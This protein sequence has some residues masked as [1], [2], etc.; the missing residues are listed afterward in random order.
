MQPVTKQAASADFPQE[1]LSALQN[2]RSALG[3]LLAD[4]PG[5]AATPTD[6]QRGL[7]IDMTLS[8]KIHKVLRASTPVAAGPHVPGMPSMRALLKAAGRQGVS[9]ELI[10]ATEGAAREFDR[11][12]SIHAGDRSTFESMVC[13][14][15]T[16]EEAE[17]VDLNYR[18]SAYRSARHIWG[19]SAKTRL[20]CRVIRP[21]ADP[22]LVDI[23]GVQGYLSLRKL[24]S[25]ARLVISHARLTYDNGSKL[26]QKAEPL[27][28][29]ADVEHG[30]AIVPEFCSQPLPTIQQV[31]AAD[32]FIAGELCNSGL[33]HTAATTCIVGSVFRDVPARWH[34]PEV[35]EAMK[36]YALIRMPCEVLIHDVFVREGTFAPGAPKA[37]AFAECGDYADYP[38]IERRGYGARLH[39]SVKKIGRGPTAVHTPDVP[40]YTELANYLF[41]RLGVD[42]SEYDVY[43]CRIEY[44]VMPSMALIMFN[45]LPQ[46]ASAQPPTAP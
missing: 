46:P 6:I 38:D 19:V 4:V 40:R 17:R 10:A 30:I 3:R 45:L 34:A 28:P 7:D 2:L 37:L 15:G 1:A 21:C 29:G 20:V 27:S 8:W 33:G 35:H 44:P 42:G 14:L 31:E 18:R 9:A 16:S 32:G 41:E 12:V 25:D 24:R 23:G 43:R 39:A 36:V 26:P 5:Q 13:A 11:V 22:G